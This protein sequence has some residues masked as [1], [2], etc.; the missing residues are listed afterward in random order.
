LEVASDS[1]ARPTAHMMRKLF[2]LKQRIKH[3]KYHIGLDLDYFVVSMRVR[4]ILVFTHAHDW[5][6][7]IFKDEF[8]KGGMNALAAAEL[9]LS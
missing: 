7:K 2:N 8:S 5:A 3:K 9:M 1:F 4:Q 6:R